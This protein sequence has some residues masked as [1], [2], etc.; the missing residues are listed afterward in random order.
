MW[1]IVAAATAIALGTFAGG[2]RIIRT[3]AY[4]V[5]EIGAAQ[6]FTAET[7]SATVI[8]AAS[9]AGFPLSTTHV[10]S[11][12]VMGAGVGRRAAEVHW[13]IAG[14]MALA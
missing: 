8:L 2:W 12:A 1:V 9:Q 3:L 13:G 14:Q 10:T 6:G 5:T 4:R 11:G 7:S